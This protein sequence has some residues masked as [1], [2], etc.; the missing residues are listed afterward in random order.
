MPSRV[1]R[2]LAHLDQVSGSVEPTFTPFASTHP[3]L[4]QVTVMTYP[5][6]PGPGANPGRPHLR[7]VAGQP[8]HLAHRQP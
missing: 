2:Y 3:G 7:S 1:E 4:A 6:H 8:S 5:D